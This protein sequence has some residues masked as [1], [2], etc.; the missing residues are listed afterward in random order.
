M[1]PVGAMT[2]LD[3]AVKVIHGLLVAVAA[4]VPAVLVSRIIV[5]ASQPPTTAP[6][7]SLPD[8]F[9]AVAVG[10]PLL[11]ASLLLLGVQPRLAM[12]VRRLVLLALIDLVWVLA[13]SLGLALASPFGRSADL[14]RGYALVVIVLSGIASI[15]S[16]AAA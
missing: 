2:R 5:A 7:D 10:G 16:L 1:P 14:A 15:A 13:A 3:L 8:W 9:W 6:V 12:G 11:I 4:V